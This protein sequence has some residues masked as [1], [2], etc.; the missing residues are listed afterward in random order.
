ML[1]RPLGRGALAVVLIL[2][3]V[4]AEA[5]VWDSAAHFDKY[6]RDN[7]DGLDLEEYKKMLKDEWYGETDLDDP[8]HEAPWSE[9]DRE[10]IY[11]MQEHF[12]EEDRDQ[13]TMI[14]RAEFLAFSAVING[15]QNE[16][17]P[18]RPCIRMGID[19]EAA[20]DEDAPDEDA[21]DGEDEWADV[22]LEEGI[23]DE[24][25]PDAEELDETG[26]R[27][28]VGVM[29]GDEA[30]FKKYDRDSDGNLDLE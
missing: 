2:L 10:E 20:M 22:D 23:I 3:I 21:P 27:V 16:E 30:H 14:S 12:V 19:P 5:A 11:K 15:M 6:D 29:G 9:A 4:S 18:R 24:D 1:S 28:L 13:D 8:A 7:D 26:R 25:D 17:C